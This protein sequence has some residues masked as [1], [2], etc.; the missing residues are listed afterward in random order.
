[1]KREKLTS[2]WKFKTGI[3]IIGILIVSYFIKL[4]VDSGSN[5]IT[6]QSLLA[7][8]I[9]ENPIILVIYILVALYLIVQDMMMRRR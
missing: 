7:K 1:M 6:T 4:E 2:G 9:F 5:Y 3:A 8:L